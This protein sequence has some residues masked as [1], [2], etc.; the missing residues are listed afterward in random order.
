MCYIWA[1]NKIITIG[2]QFGSGGHEAGKRLA[3][4]LGIPLYDKEIL[5]MTAENSHF[6]ESFLKKIDE[7]RPSFL[8]LG[9]G[10]MAAGTALAAT[11]EAFVNQFYSLS[12]N[13]QAFLEMSKVL[14]N[15]AAKGPC[16]IIGRCADYIL[17]EFEPVN[18]FLCAD[19][20]QRVRR[21]MALDEHSGVTEEEMTK[22]V[23]T[24][25]KNRAKFYEYYSHDRWG[26]ASHYHMCID[27]GKVGVDGA[28]RLMCLY[29]EEFG[30]KNIMPDK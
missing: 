8:N 2:R 3:D 10:G 9:M 27:T 19:L 15:I 18:F 29:I 1:M 25:D 22:L 21:K 5:T 17:K 26:E 14:K 6:A 13:D 23:E 7:T 28:V 16:I 20:D 24:T 4:K 12:P 30:K 11:N